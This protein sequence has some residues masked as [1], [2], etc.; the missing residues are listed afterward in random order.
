MVPYSKV[1]PP[2]DCLRKDH[3]QNLPSGNAPAI[4]SLVVLEDFLVHLSP[5][6]AWALELPFA[7]RI[8]LHG[9][10]QL[11]VLAV[12]VHEKVSQLPG[13][14]L[15]GAHLLPHSCESERLAICIQKLF[16]VDQLVMHSGAGGR[17]PSSART[18]FAKD[19]YKIQICK[20]LHDG[21]MG[22]LL[23]VSAA[24]F[25]AILAQNSADLG[26]SAYRF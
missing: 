7:A 24:L 3:N 19:H 26:I 1:R 4:P 6:L 20:P 21:V 23:I 25:T 13:S 9:G 17:N 14:V 16:P 11:E 18:Y 15:G 2:L 10:H 8:L 5:L 22:T 12:R